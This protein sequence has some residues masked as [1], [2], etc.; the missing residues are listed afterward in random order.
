MRD[1][2]PIETAPK[3]GTW[4]LGC[5]DRGNMAVIIRSQNALRRIKYPVVKDHYQL[6]AQ[7]SVGEGWVQPF[8]TGEVSDFWEDARVKFWMPLPPPPA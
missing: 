8:T 6:G 4:I 2:Q 5:N 3:D 1:W 7:F